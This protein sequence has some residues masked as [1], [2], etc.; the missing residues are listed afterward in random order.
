MGIVMKVSWSKQPQ[1]GLEQSS[2]LAWTSEYFRE[3]N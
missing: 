1:L 2:P 3:K